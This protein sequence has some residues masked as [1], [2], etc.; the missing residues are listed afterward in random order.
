MTK[1]KLFAF[2]SG[3]RGGKTKMMQEAIDNVFKENPLAR[4]AI[5]SRNGMEI[6]EGT[7][8]EDVT[9]LE[10]PSPKNTDHHEEC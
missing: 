3:G 9:P 2:H 8:Y 4:V 7:T 10:L 1:R 5:V 6:I